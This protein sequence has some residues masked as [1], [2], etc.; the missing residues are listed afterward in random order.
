M[1]S[2]RR[3]WLEQCVTSINALDPQPDLI[4]HTGDLTHQARD[5]EFK[6]GLD[7]IN[8]LNAPIFLAPGNRDERKKIRKFFPEYHYLDRNSRFVQY[9]IE[10][11]EVRFIA[12]DT[13]AVGDKKGQFCSNRLS[14]LRQAL[15][16]NDRPT[17][18]FMHHPPFDLPVPGLD[19]QYNDRTDAD[20]MIETLNRFGNVIRV[21]CGHAHRIFFDM[22]GTIP[23]STLS[24]VAI[25]LRFG[26]YPLEQKETPLYQIHRY[27]RK[28][29]FTTET[30]AA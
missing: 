21:F 7:V 17:A 30:R 11:Y 15:E 1:G 27:A 4:L 19:F 2:C 12:L 13:V 24:S 9:A 8:K 5:D 6:E 16:G 20:R 14:N 18:V 23:V 28:I 29:G 26:E 10:G 22:V 3:K 25:D